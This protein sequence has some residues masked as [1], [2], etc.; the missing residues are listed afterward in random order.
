MAVCHEAEVP[1]AV[2]AVGQRV[3]QEAANELAGLQLHDLGRAV[4][5]V[6][7]PGEGNVVVADGNEAAVGN[8]DAVGVSAE[9]GENLGRPAEG[10]LGVDDPLDAPDGG[11]MGGEGCGIGERLEIAEE[12]ET[13]SVEG[14]L[15][16]LEE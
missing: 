7:L 16:P 15:Q 2:E 8:G 13:T 12:G 10:L 6:V 14:S 11:K 4:V 9:I 3:E 5:T 1:D